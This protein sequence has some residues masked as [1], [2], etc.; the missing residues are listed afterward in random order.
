MTI[1]SRNGIVADFGC[2]TFEL[3]LHCATGNFIYETEMQNT[4]SY[5]RRD[6]YRL[7]AYGNVIA[8]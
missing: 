5:E 6:D 7:P 4:M 8:S 3:D 2:R 1:E